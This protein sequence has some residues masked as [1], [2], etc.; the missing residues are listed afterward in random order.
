MDR[1]VADAEDAVAYWRAAAASR[2]DWPEARRNVERGLL[3]L[4]R[5]RERRSDGAGDKPGPDG[6]PPE[7]APEGPDA[8]PPPDEGDEGDE[9][10]VERGE[11]SP[12]DVR[13]L[14]DVLA[15]KE[16]LKRELRRA[17]R[18]AASAGVERD[19]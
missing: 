13:A 8:P 11:L 4:Q 14:L 5:L 16:A 10:E 7:N 9:A 12:E 15:R 1:A 2:D 17:K 19:W 18:D 3:R 6:K